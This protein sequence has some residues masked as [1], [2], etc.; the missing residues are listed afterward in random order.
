MASIFD[1]SDEPRYNIKSVTQKTEIQSVTI[2]AWERRYALLT[3]KRATNGYRL[4]SERDIAVLLWVK[5]RIEAGVS[6]SSAV[7]EFQQITGAGKWPDAVISDKGPMATR[8]G[9]KLPAE[10]VSQQLL[11]ALIRH[12]E[13]VAAL[14]F[15]EALGSF[16]LAELFESVLTPVLVDIGER[17]ARGEIK[18]ATEHF[19]SNFIQ[20][21]LQA[22]FQSLPLRST[23]PRLMIGCAPD[24]LHVIGPLM[25]SILL[26]DAGYKVEFLGPDI[27]LDDL[28]AY[29]IDETPKMLILSATLAES[30]EELIGFPNMVK[31]AKQPPLFGFGGAAFRFRQ[32][33]I[34]KIDGLFLGPTLRNSLEIVQKNVPLRTQTKKST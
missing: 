3:P 15:G 7:N 4:Y 28:A 13:K 23:A 5:N 19:A 31:K 10:T 26:R 12:D 34:K 6:I 29:V 1:Y 9:E 2:R 21:R 8:S 11:L 25:L 18:V 16:D 17:W 33:L 22:I 27:P 30:A 24:E 20:S 14:V 32:E